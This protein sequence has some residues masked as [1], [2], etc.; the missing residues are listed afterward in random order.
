MNDFMELLKNNVKTTTTNGA[1]AYK[2]TGSALLDLNNS[3]PLLRNKAIEYLSSG[4]LIAL[5]TI[6]SMFKKSIQEDANYTIKW[7]MYL[8]DIKGG[9]GERSSYRLILTEIANNVP[10]LIFALLQ[11]KQLQVL[12]RF[13]DLIY[14]WDTTTNKDSKNYIFNYVKYQLSED[15]LHNK[16]DESVSLLAKWLPSE[17]T[18]SR[19]TRQLATRFR[20]ALEMSSKSY[21]RMLSTLR[22]N[23]DVVERKMSN[24]QWGEINY[25]GVTSKANLIYRNA[26]MRHDEERRSKYLEDLS[27][28]DVKINAGKMYLYDIISKYK[29]KWDVEADETLEAL[30]DA[31]EVPKDYNDILVVRDGSG[32]MTTSAFGTSVSVLDIADALTIYAT[33]HNKSEY[34][35]D[36]FITFSS[37]PEIV[38]LST[39]NT[40]RD[41]LSVL[42]GYD[43]W[44]TTNVESVFDLILDT[45][46]KNKVDA[47]DL[48]STVLVVSDM[49]FNSAMGTNFNNDTLF[50]KIAKKFESVGYKL[51]KLVFWNVASYNDTVPLQKND[52]GLVIMSGFSKNNIDMILHDNLDPLEVLKAELDS[53][54]SFID[55]IISKS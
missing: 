27:N 51:P 33:Q 53:K 40:L 29:N 18:T 47:K 35:K 5:D 39:C 48:P 25:Q 19:K 14:V 3:V 11:S 49:Q 42:D 8:R 17:N 30:W 54:Y 46:V 20:K 9:L 6:Y 44:S 15:I 31:Q 50:E 7:L 26:F 4:N 38:D 22:K 2:T 32:S 16:N 24:N 52:N 36:K 41:K 10:E 23:I 34:Y 1:V 28:G 12:G 43:D 13:D 45:S 55:T 21:R 37:K